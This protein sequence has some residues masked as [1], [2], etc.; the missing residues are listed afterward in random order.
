MKKKTRFIAMLA[1]SIM[2]VS[3]ISPIT[4]SAGCYSEDGT[5]FNYCGMGSYGLDHPESKVYSY[6]QQTVGGNRT[7][8][9][10]SQNLGT[11]RCWYNKEFNIWNHAWTEIYAC[12]HTGRYYDCTVN[13]W[14]GWA[15]SSPTVRANGLTLFGLVESDWIYDDNSHT[16]WCGYCYWN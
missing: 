8:Y 14:G 7:I 15:A 3:A 4:S 13:C 1:A 9:S 16:T 11:F 10:G 5:Y 12:A 2:A 6:I